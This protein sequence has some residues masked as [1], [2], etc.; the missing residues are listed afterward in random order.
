MEN[1]KA[2]HCQS[3][4]NILSNLSVYEY[5]QF[6]EGEEASLLETMQTGF[7]VYLASYLVGSGASLLGEK[8]ARARRH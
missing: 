7:R 4:V 6:L 3:S 8:V 1:F 5:V 2:M